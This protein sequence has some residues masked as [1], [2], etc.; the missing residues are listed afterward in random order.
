VVD[1]LI[2]STDV[3]HLVYN[4]SPHTCFLICFHSCLGFIDPLAIAEDIIDVRERVAN[5]WK[6][7]MENV[8]EDHAHIRTEVFKRQM[9]KWGQTI[10]M[11]KSEETVE[12]FSFES[13]KTLETTDPGLINKE[14]VDFE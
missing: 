6:E 14:G 5:E 10:E 9:L 3:S 7:L 8:A 4:I 11:K 13:E 1:C 12:S 2:R